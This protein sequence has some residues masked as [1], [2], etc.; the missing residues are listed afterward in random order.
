VE[1]TV[2]FANYFSSY[3]YLYEQKSMLNDDVRMQTYYDAILKNKSAFQNKIVLDVGTGTGILA[4]WAAH[5][6]A[7]KVYAVEATQMATKAQKLVDAIN[8]SDRVVVI[9]GKIEDIHI[10]EQVDIIIS[11]WMGLFLL[12][13]S[14]LDSVL[15]A[16]DKWLRPGGSLYP[17]HARMYIAAIRRE[18]EGK[19]R[20]N[21]YLDCIQDWDDFVPKVFDRYNVDMHSLSS[22]FD[23][24]LSKNHSLV[25]GT[26]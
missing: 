25:L 22:D 11:E 2:G 18:Q 14:M 7:T 24:I 16:R 15:Y 1:Q 10:P 4:V 19:R 5:A 12:R 20:Y 8:V 13:E 9:Q 26:L 23:K 3:G 17:S 6:G 21:D